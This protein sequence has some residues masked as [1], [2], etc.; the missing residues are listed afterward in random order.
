MARVGDIYYRKYNYYALIN[1][2][3]Y[4]VRGEFIQNY[5]ESKWIWDWIWD[6]IPVDWL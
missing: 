5:F 3:G 4:W 6:P 2:I 1:C